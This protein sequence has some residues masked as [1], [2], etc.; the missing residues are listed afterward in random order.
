MPSK[1]EKS[2]GYGSNER[3]GLLPILLI[4]VIIGVIWLLLL[5]R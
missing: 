1:Y 2:N 4:I 3:A 5:I